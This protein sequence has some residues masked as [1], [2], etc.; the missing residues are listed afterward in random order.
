MEAHGNGPRYA[1]DRVKQAARLEDRAV[2]LR[3]EILPCAKGG[4]VSVVG[5]FGGSVDKFPMGA[6]V[7][8]GLTIRSAQQHGHRYIPMPLERMAAGEIPAAHLATHPVP[9]TGGGGAYG[10]FKY[11]RDGCARHPAPVTGLGGGRRGTRAG[12]G[13]GPWP[14]RAVT[15]CGPARTWPGGGAAGPGRT[16]T[17]ARRRTG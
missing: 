17:G 1:Y 2:A 16:G 8:K 3:E 13:A 9:L 12:G 6:V 4:V 14:V 11:E 10:L 5:V 15:A 7:D